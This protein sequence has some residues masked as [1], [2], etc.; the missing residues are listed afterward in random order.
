MHHAQGQDDQEPLSDSGGK[1][2]KKDDVECAVSD[3]DTREPGDGK[4]DTVLG[5]TI[6]FADDQGSAA[7]HDN[8]S[9]RGGQTKALY[10]PPPWKRDRGTYKEPL[11]TGIRW[12]IAEN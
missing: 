4:S 1:L 10:I 8:S 9:E 12:L 2:T 3:S 5:R 6:S 7:I 11:F